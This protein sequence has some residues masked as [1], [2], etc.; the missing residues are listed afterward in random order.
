LYSVAQAL[1]VAVRHYVRREAEATLRRL[2]KESSIV[3]VTGPRQSG[4]TTLAQHVFPRLPYRNLEDPETRLLATEDP[5]AFLR[6]LRA[7]AI[8]DEAQRAPELFSS[9]QVLVDEGSPRGPFVVTGSSDFA[10]N[11]KIGQSLA[12]RVAYLRLLP[13]TL[14][15]LGRARETPERLEALLLLGGYPPVHD[16]RADPVRWYADYVLTY[17]ER[18]VRQ[19]LRVSDIDAFQ[20]FVR[21]CAGWI[22]QLLNLSRIAADCGITVN[23]AKAWLG[24]LRASHIV[25]LLEPHHANYRKRLVKTPKLYFVDT[26]LA[27]RLLGIERPEQIAT[28]PA[29]GGLFESW[30]VGELLK[31]RFNRALPEN[32]YFWR[33][34]KGEEID[35]LVDHGEKLLPI[36]CKSGATLASDWFQ[37]LDWWRA[38]AGDAAERPFVIYGGD[39]AHRH[40]GVDVVPWREIGRAAKKV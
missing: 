6:D 39:T 34:H 26:G 32:L 20:R 38:L 18:D 33:S 9:L 4:K 24:V 21:L 17:V 16:R 5:R 30:V 28:H 29:R 13:F 8:I 37:T 3:A 14:E 2:A 35:V 11:E 27:S 12:G 15:E 40:R 22:G 19:L 7:G 10:L 31:S 25:H 36:E 1:C 23:T